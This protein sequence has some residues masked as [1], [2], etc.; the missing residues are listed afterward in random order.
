MI[1]FTS[2][3]HFGHE[4]IIKYCDRPFTSVEEMDETL[5]ENWNNVVNPGD[6][7]WHLGD[8]TLGDVWRARSYFKRLNGIIRVLRY[9]WHHDSRWVPKAG[10][11]VSQCGNAQ[12]IAI[13]IR[14]PLVVLELPEYGKDGHPQ[15]LV[16]CHYPLAVWDR[17]HYDS[18]HLFGHSHGTYENG[19]LSFDIGVDCNWLQP[20]SLTN[21]VRKMQVRGW[22][23]QSKSKVKVT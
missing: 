6:V 2:D 21:V 20:V 16:L 11:V 1:Y 9:P 15:A 8:F 13:S 10:D 17:K 19:G 4:N 14:P 23:G 5:I 18:W 12:G 7:V 3:T 22:D